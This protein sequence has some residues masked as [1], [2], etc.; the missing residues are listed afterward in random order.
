[1]KYNTIY[2]I[3]RPAMLTAILL[4]VFEQNF[5]VAQSKSIEVKGYGNA[6]YNASE[7]GKFMKT[8]LV[9]GPVRV[10]ADTLEPADSLQEK[11]FKT[12]VIP[13]VNVVPGKTTSPVVVNQKDFKW[14]VISLS[15]DIVDLDTF[16]KGKDFVY[17]Y[18]LAEIK[19]SVPTNVILGLGSDDGIKVW[20]NGKLV[21]DNWIPRGVNKDNDLVPLKLIKGSNQLLLKVQDIKGGWGF[22]ARMLDKA[23]LADQL[24]IA[25]GNGNL[26]KI[27]LLIDGGADINAGNESGITPIIA[28][29]IG[30]RD[31]VVKMLSDKGAKDKDVPPAETFVDN[32]YSS[33]KA[34]EVSGIAV[35]VAKDGN[36]LYRKG[37]GYADIKN[38]IPV[39]PDTKFRIGSVTKQFTAAAILKLQENNLLSVNDKLSKFIPDFPRG[40]EVT[41]HQLL[42]H[43]S[44]IHSYTNKDDFIS[45]VTKTVSP[46]TLINSI[47]KDPYD[48]NPGE[49]WLYNNSG[50]FLLGYIITKVS[51]KPYAEFLKETFFDPLNMKNTGIHYAGIKLEHEARGYAKNSGKYEDA[52]NWDMSWAGGAG[53][54]YSTVDDLMKWNQALYGGRVL[55]EKSFDSAITP[56]VLK[57]GEQPPMRYGYG[58]GLSKFRGEDIIGH[59]GGLHGFVTQLNYYPK[60]KLT[61]VMFSNNAEPEVNFDPTKIAEAFLWN[62][63][64]KQTSYTESSV[65]P[66]NLQDYKGRYDLSGM[67]VV[68]IT[69]ENDKL[70]SQ[71]T[72]QP[73]FEIFPLS[74]DEFFW[75]VVDARIKFVRDQKG[76]IN[77]AVLFQNGQE[78]KAKKLP[79]EHI[80]EISPAILDNYTGKYKYKENID[81]T[82]SKE[83]NKLFAQP[84]GQSKLEMSPLSETDFVIK[85]INA[86]LSFVKED[87]K[88]N[89]I[90]L[91]LN[92]MNSE[93]PRIK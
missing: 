20:L 46:D 48:F 73:K 57:N 6:S 11:V 61:V 83:N 17:A 30:G 85:E 52:I 37:F 25:A 41:I 9:A 70:Y 65:K 2:K 55:N 32:M 5:L 89:K 51:G 18:A 21:H 24:N 69:T 75:K 1:M 13:G 66:K 8:W 92:G 79:E 29:K 53:S 47:K 63:M 58:L 42:T 27:K 3:C 64:D 88:V 54:I 39:T 67:A 49:K 44:G 87:G 43:T 15:D 90:K 26:D 36:V 4:F 56:V 76:E 81:L 77:Q 23:A 80:V 50:Y 91:N 72:G 45:K 12:D 33:L 86:K 82:V 34:K 22:V 60:E 68:I 78:L 62:K 19:A 16:Y 71:I 7:A 10:G 74:E 59:S 35:L 40:D 93:L 38:K 84:T 14:Q 31:D 28:A